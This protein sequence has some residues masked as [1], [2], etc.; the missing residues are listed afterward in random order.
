[1]SVKN[2]DVLGTKYELKYQSILDNPKLKN[3]VGYCEQYSKKIVV[4][5]FEEEK[6]DDM[7]IEHVEKLQKA[8]CVTKSYTHFS[9]NPD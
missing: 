8:H 2:L 4:S 9:E 3:L 1:M 5:D 6:K 7:C